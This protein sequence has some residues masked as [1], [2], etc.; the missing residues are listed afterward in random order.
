MH[1]C[2]F[3]LLLATSYGQPLGDKVAQVTKLLDELNLGEYCEF[4]VSKEIDIDI[5]PCVT[6]EQLQTIGVRTLGQR[7]RILTA[8]RGLHCNLQR[9]Q[10]N[11]GSGGHLEAQ[12]EPD[13]VT[14]DLQ[15][16]ETGAGTEEEQVTQTG[17]HQVTATG[18]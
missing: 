10:T 7:I 3:L 5:F 17:G 1:L 4:F 16:V 14:E 15:V 18:G 8:A 9:N 6:D 12:T 2:I 11:T 13:P